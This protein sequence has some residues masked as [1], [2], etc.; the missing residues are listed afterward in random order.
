MPG[1]RDGFTILKFLYLLCR[2]KKPS[3][4]N[5]F[6]YRHDETLPKLLYEFPGCL[7]ALWQSLNHLTYFV[8]F[9]DF[10]NAIVEGQDRTTF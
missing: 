7:S 4:N 2:H 5:A 10:N 8:N 9:P 6:L 1:S 3:K